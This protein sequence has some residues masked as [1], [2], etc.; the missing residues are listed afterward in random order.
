[1]LQARLTEPGVKKW[2]RYA[3]YVRR[4]QRD[5]IH[6]ILFNAVMFL[7]LVGIGCI[8]L[9]SRYHMGKDPKIKRDKQAKTGRYIQDKLQK[10]AAVQSNNGMI[11]SLP[12]FDTFI[13]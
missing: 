5:R 9:Y 13:Q 11:T 10:L 2:I 1:M 7:L 3:L 4:Q 6:N 8:F 12:T